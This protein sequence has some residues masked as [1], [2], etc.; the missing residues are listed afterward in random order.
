VIVVDR[1]RRVVLANQQ[2]ARLAGKPKARL[3]G[4]RVGDAF[5]CANADAVPQGC[6]HSTG[7]Q[8]CGCR[9]AITDTLETGRPRSGLAAEFTVAGVARTAVR[10]SSSP[11]AA[12]Q[13]GHA[14]VAIEDASW[15]RIQDQIRLENARLRTAAAHAAAVF[16]DMAQPLGAAA[17]W[18]E[19]LMTESEPAPEAEDFVRS[20][21]EQA[22]RLAEVSQRV[23]NLQAGGIGPGSPGSEA[24]SGDAGCRHE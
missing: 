15:D 17:A 9:L 20:V 23:P 3:F 14:I 7:C 22:R 11:V 19:L 2:A 1:D 21:R 18:V 8:P 12:Q 13:H 16:R 24:A 4:Q 6:G 5:G 10:V